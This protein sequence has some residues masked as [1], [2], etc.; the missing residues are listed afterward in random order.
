MKTLHAMVLRIFFPVFFGT[1]FF[2]VF[3]FQLM[4]V[5]S[6][7]VRYLTK[8]VGMAEIGLIALYYIPKCI[9]YSLPIGL[10]FSITFTM[11]NFYMNN[12]LI[13]IY[14]SGISLYRLVIPFIVL[15]I[16]L[17]IFMFFFEE[18]VAIHTIK[19]KNSLYKQAL[20]LPEPLSDHNV[21]VKSA[22]NRIVYQ[23]NFYNDKQKVLSGLTI[24]IRDA[25][26]RLERRIEAETAEWNGTN[27][28]LQKCR[29]YIW[30]AERRQFDEQTVQH[31]DGTDFVEKPDVFQKLTRNIDEMEYTDA[32]EWIESLKKAGRPYQSALSEYYKKFSFSLTPIIVALISCSVGGILKKNVLLMSLF[33]S[34]CI[35]VVYYV[36][37][38]LSMTLASYGYI[39][40][41]A[42]AWSAFVIFSGIGI[43]LLRLT[44][45]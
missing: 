34:I 37:Q 3:V 9:V 25:S 5:F 40:P 43:L 7:I 23:A 20:D 24:L 28:E 16:L 13:S 15:S 19:T 42:G 31:M 14:G 38:M 1:I 36:T 35:V 17:S 41:E 11:G 12:E 18:K 33:L 32:Y 44:K 22:D 26:C 2:F 45:T 21:A 30:D 39:P 6:N 27:W 29:I 4:D 10:L 8:D